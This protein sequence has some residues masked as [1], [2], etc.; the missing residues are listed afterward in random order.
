MLET[1]PR[2]L[3]WG[4]ARDDLPPGLRD[5][6]HVEPRPRPS[7][8]GTRNLGA[9]VYR[10]LARVPYEDPGLEALAR[11]EAPDLWVGLCGFTGLGADRP[12]LVWYPDFQHRHLP[13]LFSKKEV[14][15]REKQWTYLRRR[16][17]GVIVTSASVAGDALRDPEIRDRLHVCPFPP[18]F[19]AEDLTLSTDEVRASYHLPQGYF[20]VCNQLWQHKNHLLVLRAL[21]A[22]RASG[23]TAPVVA[24]TGRLQ[25]Y[26]EPDLL[27]DLLRFVHARGLNDSCRFLGLVPRPHQVALIRGAEA[28]IQPSRFEG[29]G[30]IA[31]EASALGVPLLCSDIPVHRERPLPEA[32]FFP[33]DD[34][35]GLATLLARRY[36]AS[37]K[38]AE[39]VVR[40]LDRRARAYADCFMNACAAVT[41]G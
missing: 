40:E 2:C 34:V 25:D 24:F 5:A 30:A 8:G 7:A 28:V 6:H 38:T 12:L 23:R 10:R 33:P 19:P 36:P 1:P 26:R 41:R 21:D 11:T 15:E 20:L 4:A 22:L 14:E 31:D 39:D 17:Q 35:G 9:R 37:R 13:E 29:L 32:I 27:Q 18:Y 3:I 16:A